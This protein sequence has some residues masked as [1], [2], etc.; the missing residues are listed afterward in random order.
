MT[1]AVETILETYTIDCDR[2][3]IETKDLQAAA[4]RVKP[5]AELHSTFRQKMREFGSDV[6]SYELPVCPQIE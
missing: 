1:M 6:L 5:S 3:H 4:N 2:L